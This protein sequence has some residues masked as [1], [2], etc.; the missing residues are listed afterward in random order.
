[1]SCQYCENNKNISEEDIYREG[2]KDGWYEC[3]DY[4]EQ[5]IKN[6]SLR[7]LIGEDKK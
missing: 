1:M 4:I 2:Y 3:Q 7:K 6:I 5:T